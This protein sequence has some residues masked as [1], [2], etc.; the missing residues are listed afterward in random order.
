MKN[1]VE[2]IPSGLTLDEIEEVKDYFYEKR[3]YE[4]EDEYGRDGWSYEPLK[5]LGL[6]KNGEEQHYK[7]IDSRVL[8]LLK[9][10]TRCE[11]YF[12]ENYEIKWQFSYKRGF[13]NCMEKGASLS[14]HSDDED[15]YGGKVAEEVHYSALLFLT[16]FDEYEG[17]KVFFWDRETDQDVAKLKP[18]VGDLVVFKGSTMHGVEEVVSGERMNYVIFYRD[19]NP[20]NSIV[21]DDEQFFE[22]KKEVRL[23]KSLP[24]PA[25]R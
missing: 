5:Y 16:G 19:Y 14:S 7:N 1:I 10:L 12:L 11:D 13:L 17:G 18:D 22:K 3:R 8:P 20:K 4:V 9:V 21:M 25:N 15:I 6:Y 24:S 2:V 23:E